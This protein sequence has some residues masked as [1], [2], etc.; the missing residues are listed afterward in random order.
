MARIVILG[1]GES[2]AGAAVLAKK[3]GFDV[4]V[5]DTSAIK[6]KY[7]KMLNDHHI[8]WEE[9][10]H[11]E[12]KILNA[13]EV[14]KSPGIPKEAPMIQKL[15]KQGTHIISEIEFAGRYTHSKMICIT[16]SNGKTTTTSLIYHIFK[17]AGYDAGLAGNIG[18]SLALQVAE[19]PHEYYIIELSS[20]QLDNMY[21][22]RANIAILLNITPDHLDRYDYKFENYA[23]AKMR[24]TQNQ[25]PEDSFIYWNDDPV[26]K[27][28]LK[29]FDIKAIRYPFSELK[30]T[31]SIGYIEE[32]QYKIEKPTPFNME[33]ED[34]SLTGKHNL[35]NSL[36]AGIAS[37]ISGIKKE[38][39]RKS[40]GN[41]PGVEH[42]LEKVCKVAGVQYV[43]DSKATNVDA[44][45]YA[46]E[47]MKTPV[48]L[49]LGGKDKGN[50]YHAIEKLVKQKCVGLVYLGADNTK[51][52]NFFDGM[53]IPV[54]DTHN[55][56]DCVQACYEMAK[57]GQTVLLSPCCASFDLFKNMEDRGEQF[58]SLVRNL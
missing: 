50:D 29:K 53:G 35:Y 44:C 30:E 5:S 32:G 11:T 43:N 12:E 33:Q 8:E 6:D 52:H 36:A 18:R 26:I 47:S 19:D 39:I 2:G 16:G 13:D 38:C 14:I 49:I 46:L 51:L 28:E 4:F 9:G 1:A 45:W 27:K 34:L 56:K 41:F 54:R 15:M 20:F 40:L 37:N 7:K 10:H 3:E 48:I 31:G 22:F 55:M 57:P 42:R 21:D 17:E 25:T 24:I 23:D 58:K